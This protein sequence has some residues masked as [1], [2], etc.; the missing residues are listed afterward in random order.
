LEKF[1]EDSPSLEE[2]EQIVE[3]MI[4]LTVN[5]SFIEATPADDEF[6]KISEPGR[7]EV[8]LEMAE[9]MDGDRLSSQDKDVAKNMDEDK[10]VGVEVGAETTQIS[11]LSST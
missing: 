10:G 5:G 3:V 2:V 6:H 8:L 9:E 1:M 7:G 11:T 4:E